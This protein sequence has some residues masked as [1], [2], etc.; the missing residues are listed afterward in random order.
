MITL[1][2]HLNKHQLYNNLFSM[3][4]LQLM[5]RINNQY[6]H[7]LMMTKLN[8]SIP[9]LLLN[10]HLIKQD[11]RQVLQLRLMYMKNITLTLPHTK[12]LA[13]ILWYKLL[14]IQMHQS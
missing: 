11:H 13:I 12:G 3:T 5:I 7:L 1:H 8:L 9:L 14:A 2:L 10:L 6:P 4:Q